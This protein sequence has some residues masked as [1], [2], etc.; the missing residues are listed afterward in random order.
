MARKRGE[1]HSQELRDR[2]LGEPGPVREVAAR[3]GVSPSYVSK[4]RARLRLTG[5]R[6]TKQRGGRRRPILSGRED[7]LRAKLVEIPDATLVDLQRWLAEAHAIKI[8]IGA[9][10]N[11]LRR[12]GLGFKKRPTGRPPGLG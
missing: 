3:L 1:E 5:E 12:L 2:V 6:T 9:L 8:S 4:A 11:T 7:L 10:W